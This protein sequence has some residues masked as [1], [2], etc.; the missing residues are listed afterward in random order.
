[1][2][3]PVSVKVGTTVLVSGFG[4]GTVQEIKDFGDDDPRG[5]K[6]RVSFGRKCPTCGKPDREIKWCDPMHVTVTR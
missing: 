5:V 3:K 4:L 2:T 6:M 1:M